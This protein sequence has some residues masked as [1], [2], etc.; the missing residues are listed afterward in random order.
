MSFPELNFDNLP[1]PLR[2]LFRQLNPGSLAQLPGGADPQA[3]YNFLNNAFFALRQSMRKEEA[4]SLE[5]FLQTLLK[6]VS[7][8][9]N[10]E[11]KP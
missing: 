4:A 6:A 11:K 10:G 9:E 7:A 2:T 1:E 5:Q 8:P 3:V